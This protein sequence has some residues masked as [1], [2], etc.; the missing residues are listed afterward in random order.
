MPDR[1]ALGPLLGCIGHLARER[2]DV[3]LSQYDVTPAQTHVLLY[4]HRNG[5][6][7]P[8]GDLT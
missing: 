7:A 6:E 8:Q 5:G 1:K 4:L 2:M 3:R